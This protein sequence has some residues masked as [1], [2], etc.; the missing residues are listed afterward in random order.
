MGYIILQVVNQPFGSEIGTF[1]KTFH[2][3]AFYLQ[4]EVP[5]Y[6]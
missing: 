3:I 4:F 6:Y 5:V 2:L 1:I